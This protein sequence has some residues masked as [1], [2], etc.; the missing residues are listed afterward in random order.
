MKI[1]VTCP[2]HKGVKCKKVLDKTQSVQKDMLFQCPVC[3][4]I[5]PV[6]ILK[7]KTTELW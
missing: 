5:I 2:N 6:S 7:T 1:V 4:C 3:K